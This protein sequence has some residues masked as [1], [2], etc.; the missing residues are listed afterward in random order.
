MST[1]LMQRHIICDLMKAQNDHFIF[2]IKGVRETSCGIAQRTDDWMKVVAQTSKASDGRVKLNLMISSNH[3]TFGHVWK[4]ICNQGE[5]GEWMISLAGMDKVEFLTAITDGQHSELDAETALVLAEA[6]VTETQG[7]SK[8]GA[9]LFDQI[10]ELEGHSSAEYI[11]GALSEIN[12]F[13]SEDI[14]SFKV[15]ILRP[16]VRALWDN[17]WEPFC[18]KLLDLGMSERHGV[19]IKQHIRTS[20]DK[21][22][23]PKRPEGVIIQ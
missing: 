20:A 12:F 16:H 7:D 1:P 14:E 4:G 17:L 21:S 18:G 13:T 9:A 2:D 6:K 15:P 11:L 19:P 23:Q 10:Q 8:E 5:P 22:S 3:G